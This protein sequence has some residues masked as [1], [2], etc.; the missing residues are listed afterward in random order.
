MFIH[1][2]SSLKAYLESG[3]DITFDDLKEK[4]MLDDLNETEKARILF[5]WVTGSLVKSQS[6]INFIC[7][8][9]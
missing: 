6:V 5:H 1:L 3:E 8:N 7:E 9:K 4:L 2:R